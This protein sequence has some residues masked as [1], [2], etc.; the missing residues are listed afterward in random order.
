M[1]LHRRHSQT[2]AVTNLDCSFTDVDL[3]GEAFAWDSFPPSAGDWILGR[4]L[5]GD[6]AFSPSPEP[7][8]GWDFSGLTAGSLEA[9]LDLGT[10][11]SWEETAQTSCSLSLLGGRAGACKRAELST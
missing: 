3:C 5:T 2:G 9:D 6:A 7:S 11:C 4:G 8:E 10:S 1:Q